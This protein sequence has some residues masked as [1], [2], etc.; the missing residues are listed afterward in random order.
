MWLVLLKSSSSVAFETIKVLLNF[1]LF[2]EL[3][4]IEILCE[5][6]IFRM[7]LFSVIFLKMKIFFY[8]KM[9]IKK[10]ISRQIRIYID[11]LIDERR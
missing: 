2:E 3:S 4:K 1:I 5:P 11:F 6:V 10:Y 7:I 9:L 8:W